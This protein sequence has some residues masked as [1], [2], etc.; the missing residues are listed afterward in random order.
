MR[1]WTMTAGVMAL[2]LLLC[3]CGEKTNVADSDDANLILD[4][5]ESEPAPRHAPDRVSKLTIDG[6]DYTEPRKTQRRL[7]VEPKDGADS[8]KVVYSFWPNTYTNIIRTKVVKLAK[9]KAVTVDFNKEDKDHPDLIKPIYFPTPEAVV[10]EMCKMAKISKGDVVH[11]IGCG[12][13]RLVIMAVKEFGAKKGVG[14]DIEP[15]LVKKS[16]ENAVK[17]KVTEQ[18]EFKEQNALE[19]K[20]VSDASVVLLYLGDF[21]NE[22][23]QPVLQKTLK[24]GSRVVSHRFLIGDWKP[25]QS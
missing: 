8:V 2:G 1:R 17:E 13:G 9:G 25:D 21:L 14:I 23:M 4:L 11:D 7:K 5:P 20:D 6:K 3:G 10:R 15:H 24:P 18:T 19:I 16:K 12:D 22:K